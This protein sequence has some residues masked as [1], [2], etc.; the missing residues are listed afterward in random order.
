MEVA[1]KLFGAIARAVVDVDQLVLWYIIALEYLY[2]PGVAS[3]QH[4][5]L[6]VAGNDDA[7]DWIMR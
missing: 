7:D 6:V 1:E 5:L 2:Q 4:L 3:E